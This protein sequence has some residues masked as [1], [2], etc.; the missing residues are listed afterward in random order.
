MSAE[1]RIG[2]FVLAGLVLMA[3]AIMKLG[4]FSLERHYPLKVSFKDVAGLPDK[5]IVKLSGVEVGKVKGISLVGDRAVVAVAIRRVV[6]IY[7]DAQFRVGSTSIIGSK[8]LQIDQGTRAAG[9]VPSGAEVLGTDSVSLERA[10]ANALTSAEDLIKGLKGTVGKDAPMMKNLTASVQNM[11]E[12][13]ANMNDLLADVKPELTES[14]RRSK[15]VAEKLDKLLGQTN[16]L[17]A[18]LNSSTGTVG[19]LISD[20]EMKEK[21]KETVVNLRDASASVKDTLGRMNQFRVYWD[22]T[23][24]YENGPDAVKGDLGLKIV[25]RPGHFYFLGGENIGS[26]SNV[27]TGAKVD[28]EQKNTITALLGWEWPYAQ[29]FAGAIRSSF[30]VGGRLTPF[31]G[32]GLL[33]RFSLFAQAYELGRNRNIKNRK[34][35]SQAIDAGAEVQVHKWVRVGAR[36]ADAAEVARFQTTANV[37]FEDKDIAYLFGLV[38]FAS[39]GTKGRS[40]GN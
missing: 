25:P 26:E 21:V 35:N 20:V 12:L 32:E 17:M 8:F 2:A 9:V 40:S 5:A 38:T 24:R 31:A 19:T 29:F 4:D 16:E 1:S 14:M 6:E 27:A 39:A 11:R 7:K 33:G 13:T 34:F 10:M 28:Y 15:D 18:K 36:V 23:A 30:G 37:N 3:F 22:A